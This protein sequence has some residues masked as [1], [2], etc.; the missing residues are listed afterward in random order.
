MQSIETEGDYT[1]AFGSKSPSVRFADSSPSGG[2][3][4]NPASSLARRR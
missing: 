4:N 3:T 2:A 1:R